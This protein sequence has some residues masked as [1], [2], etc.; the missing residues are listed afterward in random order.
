MAQRGN[1]GLG[2]PVAEGGMVDQTRAFERPARG[3]RH[4]RLE[5]GLIDETDAGQQVTHERLPPCDPDMACLPNFRPLLLDGLQVFFYASGRDCA[6]CARPIRD[7][8]SFG[9]HQQFP[10][11]D[12]PA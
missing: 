10:A 7:G 5:R 2:V 11:P 9:A 12:H 4:V 8:L 6:A 3:L 1:E